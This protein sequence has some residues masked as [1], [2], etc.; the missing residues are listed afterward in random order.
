M[1]RSEVMAIINNADMDVKEKVNAI[2]NFHQTDT[3]MWKTQRQ[4]LEEKHKEELENAKSSNSGDG[5][6]WKSKCKELEKAQKAHEAAIDAKDKEIEEKDKEIS[7]IKA[8]V[9]SEKTTAAKTTAL[10][11][12]LLA[13]G[14]NAKYV[15]KI[16]K[17]VDVSKLE[18]DGT[19]IKDVDKVIDGVK[20]DWADMFGKLEQKAADVANPPKTENGKKDVNAFMNDLIRGKVDE[21]DT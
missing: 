8:E 20:T 13:A 1:K 9:E 10:E 17:D 2:M 6:D 15:K 11:T 4:E 16:M 21:E 18:M 14:A 3:E 19:A 7:D 5:V 12:A